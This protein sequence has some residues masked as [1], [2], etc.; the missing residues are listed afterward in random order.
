MENLC[1][2]QLGRP[3][4]CVCVCSCML[5]CV[6]VCLMQWCVGKIHVHTCTCSAGKAVTV[7]PPDI[8]GTQCIVECHLC[9]VVQLIHCHSYPDPWPHPTDTI[10]LTGLIFAYQNFDCS[11]ME[12]RHTSCVCVHA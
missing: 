12:S 4:V 7:E 10:T 2:L 3:P 8:R 1:S 9:Q 5:V 6:S 11:A